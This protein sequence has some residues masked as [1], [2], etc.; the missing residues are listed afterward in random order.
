MIVIC[1]G[2]HQRANTS[3]NNRNPHLV[4][5]V[6]HPWYVTIAYFAKRLIEI[7]QNDNIFK[8]TNLIEG[9]TGVT[10]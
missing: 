2:C 10:E 9:Y 7:Y 1:H 3:S 4:V 6:T 5:Y 8:D